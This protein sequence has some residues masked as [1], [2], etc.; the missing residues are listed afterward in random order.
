[1]RFFRSYWF[2]KTS[3]IVLV[4]L[5][6][7]MNFFQA[8]MIALKKEAKNKQMVENF[9]KLFYGL[10]EEEKDSSKTSSESSQ[11]DDLFIS[12]NTETQTRNFIILQSKFKVSH[13][14]DPESGIYKTL[15]PPPKA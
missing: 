12:S 4:L 3:T 7:N 6:F 13:E 9:I 15:T 10:N 1:M 11:L 8:E 14:K 5:F 2:K